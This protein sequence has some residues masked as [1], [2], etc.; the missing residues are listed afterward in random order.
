MGR[1]LSAFIN[2][3]DA[4][5]QKFGEDESLLVMLGVRAEQN[6]DVVL[7]VGIHNP[8]TDAELVNQG[9]VSNSGTTS[10]FTRST[11]LASLQQRRKERA[12]I[13]T[14]QMIHLSDDTAARAAVSGAEADRTAVLTVQLWRADG[15]T[16]LVE[17]DKTLS[18]E[19]ADP[20]AA[21][22]FGRSPQSMLHANFRRFVVGFGWE[23]AAF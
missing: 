5:R 6:L 3:F 23:H 17:V 7:N 22:L 2:L 9:P 18:V 13:L 19:R 15:L 11:L 4:W 1:P 12:A 20:A 21:L 10:D 16:G 8:T 14:L